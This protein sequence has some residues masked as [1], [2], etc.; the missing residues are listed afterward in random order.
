MW[1]ANSCFTLSENFATVAVI[2]SCTVI[3]TTVERVT[4]GGCSSVW[5]CKKKTIQAVLEREG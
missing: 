2:G 3:G 5:L 1:N 4:E